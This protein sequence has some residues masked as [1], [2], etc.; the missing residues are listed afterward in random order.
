VYLREG[1]SDIVTGLADTIAKALKPE[2][3]RLAPPGTA[4]AEESWSLKD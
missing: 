2:H 1:S 3:A 4:P